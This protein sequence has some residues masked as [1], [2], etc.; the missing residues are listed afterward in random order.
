[1]PFSTASTS[2]WP[3]CG[4]GEKR[5]EKEKTIRSS[6]QGRRKRRQSV[7]VFWLGW[8]DKKDGWME[9]WMTPDTTQNAHARTPIHPPTHLFHKQ[10]RLT[11]TPP[12]PSTHPT[13]GFHPST[14]RHA[15]D[16]LDGEVGVGPIVLPVRPQLQA[17]HPRRPQQRVGRAL[18]AGVDLG[19]CGFGG[20][21]VCGVGVRGG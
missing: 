11:I 19:V 8:M 1:M 16:V 7:L 21:W 17:R 4:V 2:A 14:H 5:E 3:P 6:G 15:P 12:T 13:H 20:G 9:Q 18:G 10:P